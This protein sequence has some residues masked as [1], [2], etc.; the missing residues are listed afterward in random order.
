MM[1]ALALA[2]CCLQT[3]NRAIELY[4]RVVV[5]QVGEAC[6]GEAGWL[7]ASESVIGLES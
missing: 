6:Q 4:L 7:Q 2:S 1:V 3:A 5:Q